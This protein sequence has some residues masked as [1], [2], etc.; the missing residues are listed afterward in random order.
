VRS[1]VL[2]GIGF[3]SV[4]LRNI[5]LV[6][7]S[8]ATAMV[9]AAAICKETTQSDEHSLDQSDTTKLT[10]VALHCSLQVHALVRLLT[11]VAFDVGRARLAHST[12][13]L[14][15]RNRPPLLV[16]MLEGT[17]C[18]RTDKISTIHGRKDPGGRL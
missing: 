7:A 8:A 16:D 13:V 9:T 5:L 6:R 11:A 18:S 12:T 15:L 3:G 17:I 10:L 2:V 14:T 1:G 4:Q